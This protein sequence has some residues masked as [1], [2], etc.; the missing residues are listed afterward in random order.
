MRGLLIG[1]LAVAGITMAAPPASAQGVYFGAPGVGVGVDVG[2]RAYRDYD[3]P[4]YRTYDSYDRPGHRT[5]GYS[6]REPGC[7]TITIRR[8]DG[9]V[10][11]IR[12]CD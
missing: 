7:R 10:R 9:S 12:R 11:R 4:R 3:G 1:L 2:P 6:V 5:Y 8:D